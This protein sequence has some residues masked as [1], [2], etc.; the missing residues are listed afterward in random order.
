[1]DQAICLITGVDKSLSVS[2]TQLFYSQISLRKIFLNTS[3]PL[4]SQITY[5]QRILSNELFLVS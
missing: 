5:P 2:F 4:T 3:F 1:M